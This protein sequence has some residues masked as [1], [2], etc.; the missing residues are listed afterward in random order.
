M[1]VS[2]TDVVAIVVIVVPNNNLIVIVTHNL[3]TVEIFTLWLVRWSFVAA[4]VDFQVL[5]VFL[6]FVDVC[7][8][9]ILELYEVA[10]SLTVK[11][12][13]PN[14]LAG[15]DVNQAARLA[16]GCVDVDCT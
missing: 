14:A 8:V 12:F 15:Y 6:H 10:V 2:A 1:L 9:A 13:E 5:Q 4:I 16:S 11:G 7:I 3:F